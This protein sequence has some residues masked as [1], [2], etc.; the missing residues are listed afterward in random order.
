[1]LLVE[2]LVCLAFHLPEVLFI[3]TKNYQVQDKTKDKS[4]IILIK[5]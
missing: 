4:N 5:K 1:M 2:I 3:N